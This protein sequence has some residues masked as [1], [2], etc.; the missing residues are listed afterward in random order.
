MNPSSSKQSASSDFENHVL[1]AD[2]HAA[3]PGPGTAGWHLASGCVPEASRRN[4]PPAANRSTPAACR[5]RGR[6][7][8]NPCEK[9][10]GAAA[11]AGYSPGPTRTRRRAAASRS[12]VARPQLQL[13]DARRVEPR[14]GA[15]L[16]G[17]AEAHAA[18]A[19]EHAPGAGELRAPWQPL[20]ADTPEQLELGPYRRHDLGRL[21]VGA[22]AQP[23]E[24]DER[25]PVQADAARCRLEVDLAQH[26]APRAVVELPVVLQHVLAGRRRRAGMGERPAQAAGEAPPHDHDALEA[27][28]SRPERRRLQAVGRVGAERVGGPGRDGH[29]VEVVAEIGVRDDVHAV[30]GYV[31]AVVDRV[32]RLARLRGGRPPASAAASAAVGSPRATLQKSSLLPLPNQRVD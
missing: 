22:A 13:V 11:V 16:V 9:R 25:R 24:A 27:A 32:D 7:G 6:G 10:C 15:G 30:L 18:R 29:L 12:R 23:E 14:Q 2:V 4:S 3:Q 31:E 26:G 21:A 5:S 1:P 20:V 8:R 28:V 17:R 19:V